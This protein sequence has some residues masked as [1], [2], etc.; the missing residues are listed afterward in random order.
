MKL[1]V[2]FDLPYEL[3][4]EG[5]QYLYTI[6]NIGGATTFPRD[7]VLQSNYNAKIKY[8]LKKPA[9]NSGTANLNA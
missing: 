2:A 9:E 1:G 8:P 3:N 7:T 5:D 4:D 6:D